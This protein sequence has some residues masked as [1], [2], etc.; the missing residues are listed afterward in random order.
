ME[1]RL[2]NVTIHNSFSLSLDFIIFYYFCERKVVSIYRVRFFFH[3]FFLR[4]FLNSFLVVFFFLRCLAIYFIN[5]CMLCF[6]FFV[7]AVCVCPRKKER[8]CVCVCVEV[9][10]IVFLVFRVK[11]S[12]PL[13]KLCI[14]ASFQAPSPN[15]KIFL[16]HVY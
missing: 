1:T 11:K 6:F 10:L 7:R 12:V 13:K 8:E 2:D 15:V 16:L 4:C 9:L 5:V 3:V 14:I